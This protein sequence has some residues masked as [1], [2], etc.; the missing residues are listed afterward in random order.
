MQNFV[1]PKVYL[2]GAT[3][4]DLEVIKDYLRDTDQEEFLTEIEEAQNQGLN[5]GEILCSFYAKAC[6]ASLTTRKNKNISRTR[7]IKS[8]IMG[9]LNSGHGSVIEHC[10]LN[11]MVTNCSRVFTHELIRHRVGTSFS[12]T[13]GRYVRSDNLNIVW[14]VVLGPIKEH[15]E[16]AR[17]FL[18]EWY[19]EA[20]DLLNMDEIKDFDT[21]KKLT[22]ALRRFMPNGQANEIG[23]GVNL[24]SLRHTIEMRTSA[25]AEWEIRFVFNQIYNLVKN[26]YPAMFFDVKEEKKDGLL[27]I[28]FANKKV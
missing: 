4:I 6:Y 24:R 18:E 17:K 15:C 27:E 20:Q 25:H 5:S 22:S 13:S 19:R 10:Y 14:D 3:Q 26:K 16:K 1:L 12:Q 8:N 28:T 11:F 9:I 7:D 23:F 21:K 2:L